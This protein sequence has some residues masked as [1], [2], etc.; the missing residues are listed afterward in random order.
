MHYV[1]QQ[2]TYTAVRGFLSRFETV[3]SQVA[4][5]SQGAAPAAPPAALSAS[6]LA[7]QWMQHDDPLPP[8]S[9]SAELLQECVGL[10]A[11]TAGGN[12]VPLG[13]RR[14]GSVRLYNNT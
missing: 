4:A 8:G 11:A 1:G 5:G 10:P 2:E 12:I 6:A 13:S 14:Y 7:L 9:Y 3:G